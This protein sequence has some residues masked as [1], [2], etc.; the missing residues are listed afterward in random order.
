MSSN[1]YLGSKYSGFVQTQREKEGEGEAQN[2]YSNRVSLHFQ[3]IST[4]ITKD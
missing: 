2:N 4:K 3:E 1:S